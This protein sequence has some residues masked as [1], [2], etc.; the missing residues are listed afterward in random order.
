MAGWGGTIGGGGA[1]S[2]QP[3]PGLRPS[4]STDSLAMLLQGDFVDMAGWGGTRGAGVNAIA[5]VNEEE[6]EEDNE[7]KS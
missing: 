5:E 2:R 4:V 7:K 1:M 3:S 6:H